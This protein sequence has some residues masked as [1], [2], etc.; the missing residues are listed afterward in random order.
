M[1]LAA[2]EIDLVAPVDRL[3]GARLD[4]GVAARAEVEVD[5]I[6]LAPRRLE[7]AE[8]AGE[9]GERAAEHR[10]VAHR[11]EF[12]AGDAAGREHGD[13]EAILER[14]GP[15]ER[16]IRGTHDQRLAFGAIADARHR[17]GIGQR[18][19]RE[20]RRELGRRTA[21]LGRPAARLAQVDEADRLRA[22]RFARDVGEQARLLRARD[23]HVTGRVLGETGELLLAEHRAHR[24]LRRQRERV[25]KCAGVDRRGA[26]ARAEEELLVGD[27]QWTALRAD[28]LRGGFALGAVFGLIAGRCDRRAPRVRARG[29]CRP[30][31]V[32]AAPHPLAAAAMRPSTPR[33]MRR[34][35][36]G[37]ARPRVF[38]PPVPSPPPAR[39]VP[40]PARRCVATGPGGGSSGTSSTCPASFTRVLGGSK[41]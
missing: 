18:R 32:G 17:I 38:V 6:V 3:L 29:R 27:A 1:R 30:A 16:R 22:C 19:L 39:P 23:D 9:A 25:G 24:R 5:R 31:Q 14:V 7:R 21:R 40:R 10:I 34:R 36:C 41:M 35:R 20:Q 11:G 13:R 15:G 2:V 28:A 37:N 33:P 8:P 4:A 12:G 26:V